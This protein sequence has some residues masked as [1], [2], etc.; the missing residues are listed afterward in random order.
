[1]T[2]RPDQSPITSLR[3]ERVR[4]VAALAGRSARRK[5]QS[6]RVEGPQSIRSLLSQ[7]ADLARELFVTARA[8]AAHPELADLARGA[9]VPVHEVED[10]IIRAMVREH[11]VEDPSSAGP[12]SSNLGGALVNPQG[13]LALGRLPAEESSAATAAIGALPTQGPVTV[14]VLHE[15]RDPGNVGTLIRTADAAGADLVVLT[16]TCADPYAPKAVRAGV[17]SLFHLPVVT[18]AEIDEVLETLG[19]AD[20]ATA[21][22]SGYAQDELFTA[23]LPPRLAWIFGNEA[24]GLDE[25][26]LQAASFGVRIPLAGRAESL[27]V[28]TAATVCLFETLRRRQARE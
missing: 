2:E 19:S 9:G 21:A 3:S 26:T 11:D 24:H 14:V 16:R 28:H 1:M 4:K 23:E 6:F 8:D 20:I 25:H 18:G 5:Q 7:R 10:Q 22:T 12:V 17:G 15:V 13:A 27:N